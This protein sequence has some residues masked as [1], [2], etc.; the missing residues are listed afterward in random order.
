MEV[1]HDVQGTLA[2]GEW[3]EQASQTQRHKSL[4]HYKYDL[5]E[6][7]P[8]WTHPRKQHQPVKVRTHA[9][10]RGVGRDVEDWPI[11]RQD[12]TELLDFSPVLPGL[13]W[14]TGRPE[15]VGL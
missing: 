13:A 9:L 14:D 7:F 3:L 1:A 11:H 5:V 4:Y 2:N 15:C 10:R 6:A 8:E 12:G